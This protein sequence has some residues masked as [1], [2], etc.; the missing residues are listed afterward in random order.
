MNRDDLIVM[1]QSCWPSYRRVPPDDATLD[2]LERFAAL[3]AAHEREE[4]AKACEKWVGD[5][6]YSEEYWDASNDCAKRI[7]ARG[8]Q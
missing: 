4:C 5:E 6:A 2:R 1:A 3:I 7:L 8:K